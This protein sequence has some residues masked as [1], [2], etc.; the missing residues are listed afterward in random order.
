M[1]LRPNT[2]NGNPKVPQTLSY[3]PLQE[4]MSATFPQ[5][6]TS[7]I[8]PGALSN[9]NIIDKSYEKLIKQL[10]EII[11]NEILKTPNLKQQINIQNKTLIL[12]HIS[13]LAEQIKKLVN[14]YKL[15]KFND[16]EKDNSLIY[17]LSELISIYKLFLSN[18]S[19]NNNKQRANYLNSIYRNL[20]PRPNL[21]NA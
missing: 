8:V 12:N 13:N 6:N 9:Q 4:N 1:P 7:T 19:S 21:S 14:I 11:H 5:P 2:I 17:K 18:N 16:E 20:T 15:P 10:D 3:M